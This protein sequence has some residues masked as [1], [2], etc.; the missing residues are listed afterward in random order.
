MT[1]LGKI[2]TMLIFIMSISFMILA[3]MTFATHRNWRT[4]TETVNKQY[5]QLL[6]DYKNAGNLLQ[7]A[8]TDLATEQIAR[9]AQLGT[10][11]GKL[12]QMQADLIAINQQ[13]LSK[14]S[15]ATDASDRAAKLADAL[16]N[17]ITDV[18]TLEAE[19]RKEQVDRQA[20]F[21]RAVQLSELLNSVNSQLDS[22]KE[23]RALLEE[24]YAALQAKA[25][26]AGIDLNLNIPDRAPAIDA[27]VFKVN[28][29]ETLVEITIGQ[30]DG[31]KKGHTMQVFR[32]K[33]FLGRITVQE[34]EG[35]RA[36][37][38]VDAKLK[39]GQIREGDHVTTKLN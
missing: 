22:I 1:L 20:Q 27:V 36:V 10:L 2:F 37:A 13:L 6:I 26:S 14:Q 32:G 3:M 23:R 39:R 11:Q 12:T 38:V 31:I 8:K 5:A 15:E 17:K 28:K 33:T 21:T 16:A 25:T 9:K 34:V 4:Q 24:Q 19:L 35:D 30:D 18:E 29:E 7:S